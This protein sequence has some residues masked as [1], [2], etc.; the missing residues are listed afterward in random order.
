VHTGATR[1]YPTTPFALTGAVRVGAAQVKDTQTK[2]LKWE[3][4]PDGN[5]V[6]H[7]RLCASKRVLQSPELAV[8]SP[9][10]SSS[11]VRAKPPSLTP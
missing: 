1:R 2:F 4:L 9:W 3:R 5:A 11:P 10:S 8:A 6:R 7:T